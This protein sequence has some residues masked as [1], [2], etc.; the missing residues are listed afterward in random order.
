MRGGQRHEVSK[1]WSGFFWFS[2]SKKWWIL[3]L[4]YSRP[5]HCCFPRFPIRQLFA[6]C[7][8]SSNIHSP[9]MQSSRLLAV[10]LVSASP[11]MDA[12]DTGRKLHP[13]EPINR[14]GP[15]VPSDDRTAVQIWY[16]FWS[17]SDTWKCCKYLSFFK[18]NRRW[19]TPFDIISFDRASSKFFS[20]LYEGYRSKAE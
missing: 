20:H 3:I 9:S 14:T 6:S 16:E 11:P 2:R 13:N 8:K 17:D 5:K 10:N 15:Y 12:P 18:E 19:R 7:D 4:A 1:Q